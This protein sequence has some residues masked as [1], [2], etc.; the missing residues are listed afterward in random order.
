LQTLVE[1]I[2]HNDRLCGLN[3]NRSVAVSEF[4]LLI[5]EHLSDRIVS[6]V[7]QSPCWASMVDETTSIAAMCC[8]FHLPQLGQRKDFQICA[9]L[10]PNNETISLM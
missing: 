1:R 6:V 2:C 5:S 4:I 3:H 10:K 9:V 7:N 8:P